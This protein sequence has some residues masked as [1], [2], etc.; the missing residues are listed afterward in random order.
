MVINREGQLKWNKAFNA[1]SDLST[2]SYKCSG[3]FSQKRLW[4][5]W[6]FVLF[7]LSCTWWQN[8][9]NMWF[10]FAFFSLTLEVSK[11]GNEMYKTPRASS[12][13]CQCIVN[14]KQQILPLW[15]WAGRLFTAEVLGPKMK[16]MKSSS[17][18]VP[19]QQ[20]LKTEVNR[21]RQQRL[22]VPT[23]TRLV[24]VCL[25]PALCKELV[26]SAIRHWAPEQSQHTASSCG[27][28]SC[29]AWGDSTLCWCFIREHNLKGCHLPQIVPKR[30][31]RQSNT[32]RG[33][34]S[35][36]TTIES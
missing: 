15:F 34:K 30:Q 16:S 2:T 17:W 13:V 1:S 3:I 35:V 20:R 4:L 14:L 6:Q 36:N 9:D 29:P 10:W 18:R 21:C 26:R 33:E 8:K 23:T 19:H 32:I 22:V 31:D 12:P 7:P 5:Y 11:G 25:K 28:P 27:S 24:H